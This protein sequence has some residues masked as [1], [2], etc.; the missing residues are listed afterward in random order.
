MIYTAL[1]VSFLILNKLEEHPSFVCIYIHNNILFSLREKVGE[2]K[3]KKKKVKGSTL[4]FHYHG[5]ESPFPS[6]MFQF[7]KCNESDLP[8][9]LPG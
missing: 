2:K 5:L 9:S 4:T 1:L 7:L 8:D 6:C 3:K